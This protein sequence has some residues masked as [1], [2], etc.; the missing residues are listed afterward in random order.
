M[1]LDLDSRVRVE[2]LGTFRDRGLDRRPVGHWYLFHTYGLAFSDS[3]QLAVAGYNPA[4]GESGIF[5]VTPL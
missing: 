3:Q 4:T 1:R 5:L 2:G